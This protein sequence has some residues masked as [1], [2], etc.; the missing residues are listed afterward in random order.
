MGMPVPLK[1]VP[2]VSDPALVSCGL[3]IYTRVMQVMFG[4]G[5][6]FCALFAEL[7]GS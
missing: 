7:D 2:W 6:M 3:Q 1:P 4:N 5:Y